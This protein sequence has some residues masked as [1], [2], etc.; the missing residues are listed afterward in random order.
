MSF[1]HHRRVSGQHLPTSCP[2]TSAHPA[3]TFGLRIFNAICWRMDLNLIPDGA[4][5]GG[6]NATGLLSLDG[7]VRRDLIDFVAKAFDTT[8]DMLCVVKTR[9][10]LKW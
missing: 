4:L 2:S 3:C 7:L 10:C 5:L 6:S 8:F 1:P 9:S